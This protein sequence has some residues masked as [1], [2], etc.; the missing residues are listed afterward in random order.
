MGELPVYKK[1][2]A[3]KLDESTEVEK[4]DQELRHFIFKKAAR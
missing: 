3:R 2:G 4:E 1:H